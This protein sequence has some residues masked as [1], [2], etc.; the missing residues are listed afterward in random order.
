[1]GKIE[2][3][4]EMCNQVVIHRKHDLGF[5]SLSQ[6]G[7]IIFTALSMGLPQHEK[8]ERVFAMKLSLNEGGPKQTNLVDFDDLEP[9]EMAILYLISKGN[10]S[11]NPDEEYPTLTYQTHRGVKLICEILSGLDVPPFLIRLQRGME[12]KRLD[13]HDMEKIRIKIRETIEYLNAEGANGT[14]GTGASHN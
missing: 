11:T 10:P 5:V 13:K 9:L 8:R 1:M 14:S 4:A 6:G 3:L 2:E 7:N 12:K